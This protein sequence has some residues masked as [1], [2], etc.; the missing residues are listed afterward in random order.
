[1]ICEF[2]CDLNLILI[3]VRHDHVPTSAIIRIRDPHGVWHK[4]NIT[5]V[6]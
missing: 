5:C 6:R 3:V 4:D 1:M 2:F